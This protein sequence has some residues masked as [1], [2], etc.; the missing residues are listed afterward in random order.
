MEASSAKNSTQTL[1]VDY[2]YDTV[3]NRYSDTNTLNLFSLINI[4]SIKVNTS[5]EK[6]KIKRSLLHSI[7]RY[8]KRYSNEGGLA[9]TRKHLNEFKIAYL[10]MGFAVLE[11]DAKLTYRGLVGSSSSFGRPA[12]D[13]GLSFDP[14]LNVPYIPSSSVKGA[15]KAA[16]DTAKLLRD[17][18]VRKLDFSDA[19]PVD[20]GLKG[21]LLVP[22]VLTPHYTKGGKDVLRE[23]EAVP[24]PVPYLSLAPD[25]VYRFMVGVEGVRPD[26]EFFKTVVKVFKLALECGIGAKTSLGYGVFE[27]TKEPSVDMGVGNAK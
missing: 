13:V 4:S 9:A 7:A 14:I 19:Y 8:S 2:V 23:D 10:S 3:V 11:L 27:L 15:F 6:E 21:Y 24:V 25:S 26:D 22:D 18:S 20:H 17:E 1:W 5:D 12:F 16:N